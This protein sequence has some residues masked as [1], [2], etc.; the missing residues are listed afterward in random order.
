MRQL[1]LDIRRAGHAVFENFF[2]GPNA[3]AVASVQRSAAGEGP[4]IIWLHGPPEVG[5]SHLLQACVGAAHQRS[6]ATAYVPLAE[7]RGMSA[8]VIGGMESLELVALD[9]VEAIAGV[10]AW[11]SAL[12][13][14]HEALLARGGRLLAASTLPPAQAGIALP[15]LRSRLCAAAVFRLETLSE[16]QRLEALQMRAEWHGFSLPEETGRY[17]LTRVDRS[18]GSLFGL[19]DRLDRAA[20]AAQK[21]LTVPFVRSVLEADG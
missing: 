8:A 6:A 7:L 11:E 20:L 12:F 10:A 16:T 18:T 19:L 13:L 5:K 3:V 1:A 4:P 15:D 9:D 14:L 2:P 21:R 17:L